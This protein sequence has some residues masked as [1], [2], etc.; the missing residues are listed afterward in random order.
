M[1][2][3]KKFQALDSS[4]WNPK[5]YGDDKLGFWIQDFGFH[6]WNP[7]VYEDDDLVF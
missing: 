5:V 1:E 4:V 3:G 7:K 2:I 6:V